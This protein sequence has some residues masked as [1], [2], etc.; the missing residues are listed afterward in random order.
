MP[1][2]GLYIGSRHDITPLVLFPE[3]KRWIY[4]D[5][6]PVYNAGFKEDEYPKDKKKEMYLIDVQT[7]LIKAGFELKEKND[8][9]RFLLF[10]NGKCELYYFHSTFFPKCSD[11]Q[12]TL[13]KDVNYLYL[14]AY[15]PDRIILNMVCKIKPLT[16][17]LWGCPLF[18]KWEQGNF[19]IDFEKDTSLTTFLLFNY[20]ENVKYIY[21]NDVGGMIRDQIRDNKKIDTSSLQKISC[22]NLL[23]YH[24][25]ETKTLA[26]QAHYFKSL[27]NI[28][29]ST[30]R[31]KEV[32]QNR[33]KRKLSKRTLSK[34]TQRRNSYIILK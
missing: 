15:C 29:A 22:I 5:S 3:I 14:S 28:P 33:K 12:R 24:H 7:E 10:K 20:V 2:V 9:E 21:L 31:K 4:I 13:L 34:R 8:K 11:M 32:V 25:R 26:D 17:L 16:I 18:Y 1:D 23:E 27:K 6:L 30:Y 19:V